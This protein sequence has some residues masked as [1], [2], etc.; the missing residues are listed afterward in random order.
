MYDIR[1]QDWTA[2]WAAALSS[3]VALPRLAWSGEIAGTVTAQAASSTGLP[4]G[5]PVLAGTV[6]AWAAAPSVGV[7][8][9]GAPLGLYGATPFLIALDPTPPP[10]P[11][12][13]RT[14]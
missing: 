10:P 13:W 6:D 1:A 5:T 12:P 3:G 2:D 7:R 4:A 9:D 14:P 11:T 8:H